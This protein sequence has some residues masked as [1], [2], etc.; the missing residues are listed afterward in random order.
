MDN[1]KERIQNLNLLKSFKIGSRNLVK[2]FN[3]F[4]FFSD[5]IAPGS[6]SGIRISNADPDPD[7]GCQLKCGSM[8]IRNTVLKNMQLHT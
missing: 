2:I 6:G 5:S 3:I 1:T 8:R 4:K 7:P